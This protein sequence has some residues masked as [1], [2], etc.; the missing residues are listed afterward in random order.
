MPLLIVLKSR[1]LNFQET[2][3]SVQACTGFALPFTSPVVIYVNEILGTIRLNCGKEGE[4]SVTDL[5]HSNEI[6]Q[7]FYLNVVPGT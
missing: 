4:I 7:D 5:K 2:S 1:S 3:G 6:G